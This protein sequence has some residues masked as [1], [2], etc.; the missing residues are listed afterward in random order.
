MVI[1]ALWCPSERV[2]EE[3]WAIRQIV[4]S[5]VNHPMEV[6]WTKVSPGMLDMYAGLIDYFFSTP[7]LRFR[8]LIVPDK[9][10]LNHHA[11]EQ[12]HN[13]WYYKMFFNLL[14][15]LTDL[16]RDATY[17]VYIDIKD[18][19]SAKATKQL[20]EVLKNNIRDFKGEIF[21]RVQNVRSHEVAHIQIADLLIG[22]ISYANRG[23]TGSAAKS[24]LVQQ[25]EKRSGVSLTKGTAR[26]S[27]KFN[28]FRW[29]ASNVP[30]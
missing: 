25:I 6:K 9:S 2:A 12:D 10:A 15:V 16:N 1:G 23:L 22:A 27:A 7:D 26:R 29:E 5:F 8:G 24:A 19:R 18:S 21:S 14:S 20:Q 11:F 13:K 17:H 30:R 28:L 4:T 3:A